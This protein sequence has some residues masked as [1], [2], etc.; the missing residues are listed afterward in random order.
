MLDLLY[1]G[2]FLLVLGLLAGY[3]IGRYIEMRLGDSVE[4]TN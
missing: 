2:I 1:L 4:N 3:K